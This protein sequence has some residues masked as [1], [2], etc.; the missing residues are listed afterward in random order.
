[1]SSQRLAGGAVA[2]MLSSRCRDA[3]EQRNGSIGGDILR[4]YT[5][6]FDYFNQRLI[7]RPN[8]SFRDR[9]GILWMIN[10]NTTTE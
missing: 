2:I 3:Q 9:F 6:W 1:M 10:Y 5:V 8:G 4:R 7:L